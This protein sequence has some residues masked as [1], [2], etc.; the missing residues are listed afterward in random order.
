VLSASNGRDPW[1][2]FWTRPPLFGINHLFMGM[3]REVVCK[4]GDV[5]IDEVF[6]VV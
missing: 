5:A 1:P 2:E 6:I 4:E 3:F